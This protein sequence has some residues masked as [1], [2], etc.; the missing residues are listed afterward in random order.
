MN[1]P[2]VAQQ[3]AAYHRVISAAETGV[4]DPSRFPGRIPLYGVIGLKKPLFCAV[5]VLFTERQRADLRCWRLN[6]SM[7]ETVALCVGRN[8][9]ETATGL[10]L[11]ALCELQ[12]VHD[13]AMWNESA[14]EGRREM[15][16]YCNGRIEALH[17]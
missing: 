17:G 15:V 11:G 1:A 4:V 10:P 8:Y 13:S 7:I 9:V 12:R 14:E 3:V 5:G 2:S 16:H 6:G